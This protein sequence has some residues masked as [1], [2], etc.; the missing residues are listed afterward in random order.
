MSRRR[1]IAVL[2]V[3]AVTLGATAASDVAGREAALKER[4]GPTVA[5]LV[6]RTDLAAGTRLTRR[7]LALRQ[8]PARY[9]PAGAFSRPAEVGGLKAA[10]AI[11]AGSDVVAAVV[12]DPAAPAGD[13]QGAPPPALR[14]G[15]RVA[16]IVARGD[17]RLLA[18][19]SRID[20]LVTRETAD[21]TGDTRLALQD[22]EV[23]A[24]APAPA[25]EDVSGHGTDA[26]PRVALS[27]RVSLR[28]AVALAAAQNFARELRVLPRVAGD[29]RRMPRGVAVRGA[30]G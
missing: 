10:V 18:P 19:G 29:R 20:L 24:V 4:L 16:D 7:V 6:T 26:G 2:S 1:R 17:A 28:E 13:A 8:V 27:L 11:P 3:L 12:R 22:A 25:A 5:V 30:G 15:E 21:G 9:V 14:A 23:L